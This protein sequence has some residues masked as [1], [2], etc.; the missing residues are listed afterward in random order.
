MTLGKI[1]LQNT[2]KQLRLYIDRHRWLLPLF[3]VATLLLISAFNISGSSMGTYDNIILNQA[4]GDIVGQHRPIRS[5]E[6]LVV[7]QKTLTQRAANYPIINNNIGNGEDQSMMDVPSRSLFTLFKPQNL[8]FFVLPYSMAFAAKWWFMSLAVFVGFY[9]LF[10]ELFPN[11]RLLVSLG[12]LL[13][14]FNPFT[15][16]WYQTITL[17]SIGYVLF[18]SFFAIKL[19]NKNHSNK[20][21]VLYGAGLAYF[22]LCFLLVLYP[23]FQLAVGYVMSSLL[24]GYFYHKY[25]VRSVSIKKDLANWMT[26]VCAMF[27]VAIVGGLF[28]Y[29]HKTVIKAMADTTYPGVRNIVSGEGDIPTQMLATFSSPI[30][31]NLQNEQKTGAF[32]TNQSE[33]SRIVALNLVLIPFILFFVFKK[34]RSERELPDYLL[35]STI[36]LAAIFAVRILTPFF[37]FPYILLLFNKV[38]NERLAIGLVL[39]C[40]IQLVLLGVLLAKKFS[41]RQALLVSVG[42][43]ALFFD[44]SMMMVHKYPN[45]V[46]GP[47]AFVACFIVGLSAFFMLQ[48]RFFMVGLALFTL[49]STTSSIFVNP[50]YRNSEPTSLREITNNIS[51][52]YT[53]DKSWIVMDSIILENIPAIAGKHSLSGV[54]YYPQLG[55]WYRLDPEH[56]ELATYNRYAH[57]VFTANSVPEGRIFYSPSPD[58]LLVKLNCDIAKQLPNSGYILSSA[59]I[60]S[61]LNSCFKE[62][63]VMTYPGITLRVYRYVL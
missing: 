11:K 41:A 20:I 16:W 12:A 33:A 46:S 14:L 29:S 47:A 24:I 6:W 59:P 53:D 42:I 8:F 3:I 17:L 21:R 51:Q 38:Q 9:L 18:A 32:Y 56:K 62:D 34:K 44:A 61:Q 35:L 30:L 2:C 49:F 57:V 27:I 52:R 4:K 5:D 22:T 19:F 58:I 43:F 15:Q 39:L 60:D 54:N 25:K 13:L 45:F 10:N 1:G 28:V 23:P 36:A 48:K 55:L 63:D 50:L 37:N 7:S 26:V 31:F 40:A